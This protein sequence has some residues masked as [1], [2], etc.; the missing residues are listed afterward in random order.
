MEQISNYIWNTPQ[1]IW[2]KPPRPSL[3]DL[4]RQQQGRSRF[5]QAGQLGDR[6]EFQED[7]Q[8]LP[9]QYDGYREGR[10]WAQTVY[11]TIG[12]DALLSNGGLL[13]GDP[14]TL[15]RDL[16]T[17]LV[18]ADWKPHV[19]TRPETRP[20]LASSETRFAALI[21]R[22]IQYEPS[23]VWL[24]RAD[25]D[26]LKILEVDATAGGDILDSL[27]LAIK[28]RVAW[29]ESGTVSVD[30]KTRLP[31]SG[32]GG[33]DVVLYHFEVVG[34]TIAPVEESQ[35]WHRFWA[36]NPDYL[37]NDPSSGH[38]CLDRLQQTKGLLIQDDSVFGLKG[39]GPENAAIDS[40]DLINGFTSTIEQR[41]LTTNINGE[42]DLNLFNT[43]PANSEEIV[44]SGLSEEFKDLFAASYNNIFASCSAVFEV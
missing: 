33:F 30:I 17:R 13:S 22:S 18:A 24:I 16:D 3:E 44:V 6:L 11:G 9:G 7:W 41:P 42:C 39:S 4:A 8:I 1:V 34:T 26:P 38:P 31:G 21:Y 19:R 25:Q 10:H 35:S 29:L 5:R 2:R 37:Q 28:A 32:P 14:L 43:E 20:T 27:E 12:I 36:N 15:F 40:D 23:E